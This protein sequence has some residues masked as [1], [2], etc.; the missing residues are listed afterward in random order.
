VFENII[1]QGAVLQLG[2]DIVNHH[3]APSILF[4]GPPD[5]GKSS[6]ALE[7]SRVL[8]CENDSAWKCS[9]PSCEKHR[10]LM[11]DDLLLLTNRSFLPVIA[12]GKSAFLR[13]PANINSRLVFFR[14]L[15]RLL[16]CFSPVLMEDDPRLPK[17]NSVLQSLDEKLSEYRI[18]T[19]SEDEEKLTKYCDSV[20][21]DAVSL[22]KDGFGS[23]ITIGQIR[24]ASM[25]CR[26]AP[27]GKHKTLVIENAENMRDEGRNSLL[28]LLE[29]PPPSVSIVLTAQRKEAIMPTILSRL[30]PYR[31]LKRSAESEKKI[32]RKVFQDSIDESSVKAGSSLIT[33]Y[34]DSFLSGNQEKLEAAAAWFIISLARIAS[35][36]AKKDNNGGGLSEFLYA[37]EERYAQIAMSAEFEQGANSAAVV[38]AL[39]GRYDNFK[40]DS[41]PRFLKNCLD[42][43]NDVTRVINKPSFILYNDI[44]KKYITEAVTAVDILNM[45][46]AIILESL[47]YK[48][49]K[50]LI[51]GSYD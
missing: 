35:L 13:N 43:V 15:R 12:A 40:D 32:I 19:E 37:A 51:R 39:L 9:C 7:L 30:R 5:S 41:F 47:L 24:R 29:E 27:N 6:A 34:F 3:S 22:E 36:S 25:W 38:K 46:A 28:K 50:A 21:K 10:Y 2:D 23:I 33:A 42:I 11:H 16:L 18:I 45:N 1:E 17:I 31:F 48:I 20:V 49:K 26:L 44:L 4:F 14:S 8:S